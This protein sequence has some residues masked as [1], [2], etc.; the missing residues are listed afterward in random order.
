MES[1]VPIAHTADAQRSSASSRR[2]VRLV[3]CV[4]YFLVLLD[5]PIVNTALPRIG[6]DLE[7]GLVSLQ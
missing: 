4:G 2:L 1:F 3:M 5:V 7:A 6:M